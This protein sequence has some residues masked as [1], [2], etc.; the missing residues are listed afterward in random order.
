MKKT[1]DPF[2][3][4]GFLFFVGRTWDKGGTALDNEKRSPKKPHK[5]ALREKSLKKKKKKPRER[6]PLA[7]RNVHAIVI[8]W[9]VEPFSL[10]FFAKLA[11]ET[12]SLNPQAS[13]E[14]QKTKR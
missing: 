10:P 13:S 11:R 1:D 9:T 4:A 5:G 14:T 2:P 7:Q 6:G 12:L 8:R 3:P